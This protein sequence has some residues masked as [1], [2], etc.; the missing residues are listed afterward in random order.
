MLLVALQTGRLV[1]AAL[2][3]FED[4]LESDFSRRL[5]A[6]LLVAYPRTHDN[7]QVTPQ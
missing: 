2:D 1:E 3:V 7:L 6:R 5:V 4:E